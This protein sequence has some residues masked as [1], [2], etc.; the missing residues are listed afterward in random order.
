MFPNNYKIFATSAFSE[1]DEYDTKLKVDSLGKEQKLMAQQNLHQAQALY[2]LQRQIVNA[3]SV[4][5]P[6]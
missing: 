4:S 5:L 6:L 1:F 2:D 3:L